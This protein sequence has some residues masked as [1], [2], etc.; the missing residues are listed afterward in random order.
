MDISSLFASLKWIVGLVLLFAVFAFIALF[1]SRMASSDTSY[2][3]QQA[4]LRV[5]TLE[6]LRAD[7]EKLLTTADW[8]D[9][10]ANTVRLPLT[11]AT[12]QHALDLV[13]AKGEPHAGDPLPNVPAPTQAPAPAPTPAPASA[14]TPTPSGKPTPAPGVK[15]T[16]TP[17]KPSP[18]PSATP[19]KKP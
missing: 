14:T 6:K 1:T 16:A 15:P 19:T 10:K 5:T 17:G 2:D 18:A 9:K 7:D 13:K 11:D 4:T 12:F 8:V 3:D